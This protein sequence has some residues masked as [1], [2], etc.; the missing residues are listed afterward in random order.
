MSRRRFAEAASAAAGLLFACV[1][2]ERLA[3]RDPG[4]RYIEAYRARDGGTVLA[5]LDG[6]PWWEA[7]APPAGHRHWVQTWAW[8]GGEQ[9]ERCPCGA[10]RFEG[11]PWAADPR[12]RVAGR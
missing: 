12:P 9:V 1:A 10:M 4:G 3:G 2:R 8:I 6:V 5:H 7:P 11:G